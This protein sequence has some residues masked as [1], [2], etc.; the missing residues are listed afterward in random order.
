MLKFIGMERKRIVI[1]GGG[2]AGLNLARKLAKSD[3]EIVL[4]DKQNHHMFQPLFYQV[5]P[6][7]FQ[8]LLPVQGYFQAQEKRR[9][10]VRYRKPHSPRR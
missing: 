6:G 10:P 4:V 9:F 8:Y 2:F 7:T 1:I 5:A 3:C